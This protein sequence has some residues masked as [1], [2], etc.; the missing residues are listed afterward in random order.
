MDDETKVKPDQPEADEQF[1]WTTDGAAAD[2]SAGPAPG[3]GRA[4]LAQLQSMIENVTEQAA[5]VL[6]EVSAK[7]AELAALAGEKAGP[8]AARAAELTAEAGTKLAERSRD[9]AAELRRIRTLAHF[10]FGDC[11]HA[12]VHS[13]GVA[14]CACCGGGRR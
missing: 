5:P 8:F 14:R 10:H 11:V 3:P 13:V 12:D 7:A 2:P 6:R 1:G 9:L 4:W